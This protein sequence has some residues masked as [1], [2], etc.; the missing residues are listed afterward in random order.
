MQHLRGPKLRGI[1]P[2]QSKLGA[3]ASVNEEQML[4]G[5]EQISTYADRKVG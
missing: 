4:P 3:R 5:A 1:A 2:P